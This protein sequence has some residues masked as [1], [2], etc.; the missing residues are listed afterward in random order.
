MER[1]ADKSLQVATKL[2]QADRG[3]SFTM[4][5]R[6]RLL[7]FHKQQFDK[8]AQ[9]AAKNLK[10]NAHSYGSYLLLLVHACTQGKVSRLPV[11]ELLV[12]VCALLRTCVYI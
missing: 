3:C 6:G 12:V 10:V 4:E 8:A 11:R 2:I 7:F 9:T 5:E 1:N